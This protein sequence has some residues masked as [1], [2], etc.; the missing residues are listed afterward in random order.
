[1]HTQI[2]KTTLLMIIFQT[3]D[4]LSLNQEN[5]FL[6]FLTDVA[7]SVRLENVKRFV[8]LNLFSVMRF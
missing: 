3:K 2:S 7:V 5:N 8:T 4:P 1:M 6:L